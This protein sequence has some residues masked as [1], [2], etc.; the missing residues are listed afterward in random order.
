VAEDK[1]QW[2]LTQFTLKELQDL[3]RENS[4]NHKGNR[5]QLRKRLA[6]VLDG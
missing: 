5:A 2:D 6:S 1:P 3:C 4:L